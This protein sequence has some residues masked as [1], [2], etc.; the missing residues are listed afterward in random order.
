MQEQVT[1]RAM[2]RN[3]S[4]RMARALRDN[5]LGI[6]PPEAFVEEVVEQRFFGRRQI[7]LSRSA[8]I[9]HIL[10]DNPGNYRRTAVTLRILRPLLGDGLLLSEGEDWQQQRRTAAPAFAPRTI[11]LVARHVAE[12]AAAMTA[13]L[14]AA[15]AVDV[16]ILAEMRLLALEIAGRALFSLDMTPF[17]PEL[18]ALIALYAARIGRPGFLDFI[19]PRFV[20]SPRD[21]ARR[22]FR[23][24]WVAAVERLIEERD[25]R[26]DPNAGTSDLYSLLESAAGDHNRLLDQLATFI[27][28]GHE[29]TAVALFWAILLIAQNPAA[30]ERLAAEA[31][32]LDLSPTNAD[33]ALPKLAYTRAVVQEALRLYPPAF[34]LARQ[35]RAADLAGGVPIPSGAVV[36]IAP[37]VLHRHRKLWL[38]PD[39]FDP[40]RFLPGAPP[41]GRFAYLPFGIGPRVCIGAQF[42]LTEASL[43]LA[44]LV[45]KFEIGRAG[46]EPVIPVG[47]VTTQPAHPTLFRLRPRVKTRV[48][49]S[50]TAAN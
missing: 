36:L 27:V 6:F 8:A 38:R 11:P 45:Q 9:Q 21:F 15:G 30:Q 10:I 29:T 34:T 41:P 17:G 13:R 50:R 37:W 18:R 49:I 22:R 32:S 4:R 31:Q 20:P 24:Q 47:V 1:G 3:S 12:R 2:G 7:I 40:D 39:A 25:R 33:D 5:A 26:T 35:A 48:M 23:R 14:G 16:D 44:A 43:V 46:D 42:A 19:L 28:A